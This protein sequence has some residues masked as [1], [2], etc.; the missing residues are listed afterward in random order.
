MAG[1]MI[2][3]SVLQGG[4]GLTCIHPVIPPCVHYEAINYKA[5][6]KTESQG[7]MKSESDER[8]GG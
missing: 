3:H 2:A 4:L 6:L 7:W 5:K 8:E 1:A